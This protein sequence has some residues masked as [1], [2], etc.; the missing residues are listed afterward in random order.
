MVGLPPTGL[1][2]TLP[3]ILLRMALVGP[4]R[5]H[6]SSREGWI[7]KELGIPSPRLV[8]SLVPFA[9][10]EHKVH[11]D[12]AKGKVQEDTAKHKVH[13]DTVKSQAK[14]MRTPS[15]TKTKSEP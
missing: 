13:E 1:E 8:E 15:S 14:S 11:E 12:T 9:C 7:S 5:T 6:P 4:V 2:D 3:A 10:A